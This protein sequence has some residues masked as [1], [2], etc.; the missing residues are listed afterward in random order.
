MS[1]P[2]NGLPRL[3]AA[4]GPLGGMRALGLSSRLVASPYGFA[5]PN[6]LDLEVALGLER[7]AVDLNPSG[8][9]DNPQ[10][11]VSR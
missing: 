6:R 3:P 2:V 10:Q 5:D 7:A 1:Q 11:R 8:F 4:W 9:F